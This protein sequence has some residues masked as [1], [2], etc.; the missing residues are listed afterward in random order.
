MMS[1]FRHRARLIA[2]YHS[3]FDTESGKIVL[4]DLVKYHGVMAPIFVDGRQDGA[5]QA[6]A[7][8]EAEGQR[9]VVLRIIATLEIS[10]S[11]IIEQ[12]KQEQDNER[13]HD[14]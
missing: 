1:R 9:A 2:A 14:A 12:A 4:A 6:L 5:G 10:L 11:D 3:V 8:A 7:M 13:T